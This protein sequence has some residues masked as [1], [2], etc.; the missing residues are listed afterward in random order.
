MIFCVA[1]LDE[2]YSKGNLDVQDLQRDHFFLIKKGNKMFKFEFKDTQ[3][4]LHC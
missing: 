3:F 2:K 4:Q 1:T